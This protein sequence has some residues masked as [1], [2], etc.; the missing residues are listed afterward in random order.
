MLM[1]TPMRYSMIW[2]NTLASQSRGLPTTYTNTATFKKSLKYAERDESKRE[3]YLQEIAHI[4]KDSIVY[5]DESGVSHQMINAY[6]WIEKGSEVIGE[7]SGAKRGRT[8]VVAALNGENINAPMAY[9]GTMN[10]ELF[11]YWLENFLAA[12][13][14]KG[15]VVVMDNAAIHKVKRVREIIEEA[16]CS[17]IYLPPYSPDLNPIE[18]I[19]SKIKAHLRR[20][21]VR[22]ERKLYNAIGKAID[23]VTSDDCLNCFRNSGYIAQ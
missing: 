1:L 2:R 17:L 19:F 20:L 8:S 22:T 3:S 16:G 6:C 11:L 5:I 9:S 23:T 12:S 21:A 18:Q 7:R 14:K 10:G 15:Q 13:L 4:A